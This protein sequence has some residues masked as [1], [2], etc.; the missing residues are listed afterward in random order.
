MPYEWWFTTLLP[1]WSP[2]A[3]NRIAELRPRGGRLAHDRRGGADTANM[4]DP[5]ASVAS[6]ISG[7][8]GRIARLT[9]PASATV[10]LGSVPLADVGLGTQPT[11]IADGAFGQLLRTTLLQASSDQPAMTPAERRTAGTYGPLTPPSEL[12]RYGNGQIPS[13]ALAPLS[14]HPGHR[15]W[16]PAATAFDRMTA[17]AAAQGVT[18][19]ITDS[20]RTLSAQERLV[21]EKGL[22]RQGGLAATP[23]TSNHGWGV[24][25]DLDLDDRAQ[26]W[27]RDNGWRY[28]FVEDVPREPWHWT[29][30]PAGN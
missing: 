2:N 18:I 26:A 17:D 29:Y 25:T 13:D 9:Q 27:M 24:A 14:N 5:L 1:R 8:E 20:Y 28:G 11:T 23:G 19:G 3:R 15:L 22:Y 16:A 7:I 4:V 6:R 10:P 21:E 12:L 30:R